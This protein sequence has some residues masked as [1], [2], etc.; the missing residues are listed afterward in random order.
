MLV[1]D[2]SIYK[3][4]PTDI[5]HSRKF[6]FPHLVTFILK[7][8][9]KKISLEVT[10]FYQKLGTMVLEDEQASLTASAFCQSRQK[11]KPSFS[12]IYFVILPMNFILIMMSEYNFRKVKD[13]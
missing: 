1:E 5:T 6:P 3:V 13:Y 7:A 11:L 2:A 9:H 8:L 10:H 12:E 4:K